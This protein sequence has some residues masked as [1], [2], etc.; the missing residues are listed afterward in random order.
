MSTI[1][2]FEEVNYN[3]YPIVIIPSEIYE[4]FESKISNKQIWNHLG[5]SFYDL[6]SIVFMDIKNYFK[7]SN[8]RTE[9]TLKEFLNLETDVIFPLSF[10]DFYLSTYN[11]KYKLPRRPKKRESIKV[12]RN[13]SFLINFSLIITFIT[14]LIVKKNIR[15]KRH[16][17]L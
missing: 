5:I 11:E 16:Y 4:S 10:K 12:D 7:M 13:S 6:R 3:Y 8:E 9:I 14:F 2:K 17:S 15:W 1:I